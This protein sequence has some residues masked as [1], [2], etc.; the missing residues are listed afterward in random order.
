M[1]KIPL[2]RGKSALVS[3]RDFTYLNQWKWYASKNGHNYYAR[4]H[5]P[6]SNTKFIYM[7]RVV[8]ERA[9]RIGSEIDHRNGNG[10]DNFRSNLRPATRRQNQINKNAAHD[11]AGSNLK[12]V[13]PV[14]NRFRAVGCIGS[15]AIHL[16]MYDTSIE[17]GKAYDKWA[18]KNYGTF[19]R[20]NF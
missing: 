7:H 4:R 9:G 10:L 8:A 15:K 17:A 16:G 20:L 14:R 6:G 13:Y 5:M 18:S 1:K 2:T 19:A 3:N 12:G 11:K